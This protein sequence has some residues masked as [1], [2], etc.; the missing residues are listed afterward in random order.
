[1][2]QDNGIIQPHNNVLIMMLSMSNYEVK[3]I[4]INFG[5]STNPNLFK[6]AGNT[7]TTMEENIGIYRRYIVYREESTR[8][9]MEKNR[10]EDISVNIGDIS[11]MGDISE[12]FS[13]NLPWWQKIGDISEI[14]R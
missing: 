5:S 1:M 7:L 13:K 4:L 6:Q 12:I 11:V 14:Y 9:F 3:I 10:R 8:Y 2:A